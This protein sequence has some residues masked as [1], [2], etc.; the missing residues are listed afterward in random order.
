MWPTSDATLSRYSCITSPSCSSPTQ[1]ERSDPGGPGCGDCQCAGPAGR[2][3]AESNYVWCSSS[4]I[5][6]ALLGMRNTGDSGISP[7]PR[8][9]AAGYSFKLVRREP[10][11][12]T[13]GPGHQSTLVQQGLWGKPGD[14]LSTLYPYSA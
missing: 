7:G 2:M 6:H 5:P 9:G 10:G 14:C 13:G 12:R 11:H 8:P 4:M 3:V 1:H